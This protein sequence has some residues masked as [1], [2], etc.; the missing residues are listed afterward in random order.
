M[1]TT[2]IYKLSLALL[3]L[4]I[5]IVPQV[6]FAGDLTDIYKKL[7]TS[8]VSS[9]DDRTII[10]GLKEALSVGTAKAVGL[11]SVENGYLRNEAIKILLPE[12]IQKMSEVLRAAGFGKEVD[13]FVLSM[14]RAAEKAAPKAK[15]IFIAAVKE[16]NFQDAKNILNGGNTAAT[17]YFQGKTST[18]LSD[19][20]RPVIS[21]SMNKTGVTRSYKALKNKYLS[22]LPLST[23]E[24]IDLDHYVT[25]KALN[26]LFYTLGQEEAKIRTNPQARTTEILKKVFAK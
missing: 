3:I 15:P 14:N 19:S 5:F 6:V 24:S 16:M 7:Q 9:L 13:A 17:E 20:F 25:T 8:S 4:I 22:I 21:S 26:G 2:K 18:K 1:K 12:K 23:T 10:S 11:V